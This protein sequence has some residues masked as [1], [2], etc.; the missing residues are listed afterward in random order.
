[1]IE[2]LII[3][4]NEEDL[5]VNLIT[6]RLKGNLL[7]PFFIVE[8]REKFPDI[9]TSFRKQREIYLEILRKAGKK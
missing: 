3:A 7:A 5:S 8:K 4:I 9:I 2:H 1:M 6:G